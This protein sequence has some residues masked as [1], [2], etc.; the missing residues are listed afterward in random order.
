[1]KYSF[2]HDPYDYNRKQWVR[3]RTISR[4]CH[5]MVRITPSVVLNCWTDAIVVYPPTREG[6][7][8]L[9][10]FFCYSFGVKWLLFVEIFVNHGSGVVDDGV[11]DWKMTKFDDAMVKYCCNFTVFYLSN[12]SKTRYQLLNMN[13]RM[14]RVEVLINDR[15]SRVV[16]LLRS[17]RQS[18]KVELTFNYELIRVENLN[19]V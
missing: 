10:E 4:Y 15:K 3:S 14:L 1:M 5:P 11:Q 2:G 12:R 9:V 16:W 7:A 17:N 8:T 13:S 6:I 19:Y 18:K